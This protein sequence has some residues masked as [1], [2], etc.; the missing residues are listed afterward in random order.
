MKKIVLLV[1]CLLSISR[2]NAQ[3]AATEYDSSYTGN[4]LFFN[5]NGGDFLSGNHQ[6]GVWYFDT[7]AYKP[8]IYSSSVWIGGKDKNDSLHLAAMMYRQAGQDYF[9]GPVSTKS[10]STFAR[11]NQLFKVRRSEV[12]DHIAGISTSQSIKDWPGNGNSSFGEPLTIAPFNDNNLDGNYEWSQNDYPL[13]RGDVSTFTIFNDQGNHTETGGKSMGIDVRQMTYVFNDNADLRDVIFVQLQVVNRSDTNYHD[14]HLGIFSDFDIG[15][16]ENDFVGCDTQLNLY[17]GYN[18]KPDDGAF[19][20]GN[21]PPAVGVLFLNHKLNAFTPFNNDVNR[22]NG[23]PFF[24]TDFYNYLSGL[25]L[26]GNHFKTPTGDNTRVQFYGDVRKSDDWTEE[27]AG[28]HPGDRRG[29]GSFGPFDLNAG[30]DICLDVAYIITRGKDNLHSVDLLKTRAA[31]IQSMFNAKTLQNHWAFCAND[32]VS[33][34]PVETSNPKVYPNPA[35][36]G[37]F[38]ET[39]EKHQINNFRIIDMAGKTVC[40]GKV[41]TDNRIDISMLSSG[42]YQVVLEGSFGITTSR[43]IKQ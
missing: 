18:G 42:M 11:F 19:G 21:R 9:P 12:N 34:E 15:D 38:I 28:N 5:S 27:S 41:Q 30:D 31:K 14:V 16:F 22:T 1:F 6:T 26:N 23:N 13:I 8:L 40:E 33:V 24:P 7:S 29:L 10:D 2:I 35:S 39:P 36:S 32:P 17:Y 25:D 37:L 20:F 3:R 4:L 43:F